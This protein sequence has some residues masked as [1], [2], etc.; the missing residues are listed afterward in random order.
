MTD[1]PV[2]MAFSEIVKDVFEFSSTAR[3]FILEIE[4][5]DGRVVKMKVITRFFDFIY[6]NFHMI[7]NDQKFSVDFAKNTIAKIDAYYEN[8]F[9][10]DCYE[11]SFGIFYLRFFLSSYKL[12]KKF[13]ESTQHNKLTKYWDGFQEEYEDVIFE[14]S[15]LNY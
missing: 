2:P 1:D 10:K 9:S 6:A 3:K 12:Y 11:Q 4:E 14:Y 8:F 15:L 13:Y 7:D 5:S